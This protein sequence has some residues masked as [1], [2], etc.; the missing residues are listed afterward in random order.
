MVEAVYSL[1]RMSNVLQLF[2]VSL[3]AAQAANLSFLGSTLL[4]LSGRRKRERRN[5]AD[6]HEYQL[7]K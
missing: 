1:S 7:L 3:S 6:N 2:S 5:I 4:T